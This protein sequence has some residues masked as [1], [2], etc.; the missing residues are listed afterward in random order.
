[1]LKQIFVYTMKINPKPFSEIII[2]GLRA[3]MENKKRNATGR[4]VESLQSIYNESD[5]TIVVTGSKSWKA[6][7]Y[8]TPAGEWVPYRRLLEWVIAKGI[9]KSATKRIQRSIFRNGAPKDKSKLGVVSTTIKNIDQDINK[10]LEKQ[11][12]AA[13]KQTIVKEWQLL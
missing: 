7:E 13:I 1:M 12:N 5:Q 8:G 3:T 4:S 10:E 6:I 2:N 9:P 11:T